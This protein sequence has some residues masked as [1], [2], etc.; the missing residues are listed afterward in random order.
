MGLTFDIFQA[1]SVPMESL[2]LYSG[3][4]RG[5]GASGASIYPPGQHL[6][7]FSSPCFDVFCTNSPCQCEPFCLATHTATMESLLE[8]YK[9]N[10]GTFVFHF[11]SFEQNT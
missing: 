3:A 1:D 2:S 8:R 11:Q 6:V 10:T 9:E 5:G 7:S 4:G